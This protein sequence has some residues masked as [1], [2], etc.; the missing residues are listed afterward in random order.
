MRLAY[1]FLHMS[2]VPPNRVDR[3]FPAHTILHGNLPASSAPSGT[4]LELLT[5]V[6]SAPPDSPRTHKAWFIPTK[7]NSPTP[8][9]TEALNTMPLVVYTQNAVPAFPTP[10]KSPDRGRQPDLVE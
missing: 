3:A 6:V 8:S 9:T 5:C 10:E 2:V 4:P 7:N 1:Y